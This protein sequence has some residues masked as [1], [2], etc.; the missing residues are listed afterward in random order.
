MNVNMTQEKVVPIIVQDHV[1]VELQ[2]QIV[3]PI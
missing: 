3:V 2:E 1:Y